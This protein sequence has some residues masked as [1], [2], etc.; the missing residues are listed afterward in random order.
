MKRQ[1]LTDRRVVWASPCTVAG[2]GGFPVEVPRRQ[3]LM[4]IYGK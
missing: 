1:P 4:D 2:V 3:E